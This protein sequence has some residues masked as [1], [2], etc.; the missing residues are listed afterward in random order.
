MGKFDSFR[1]SKPSGQ[2]PVARSQEGL[3]TKSE[4]DRRARYV[5]L[6]KDAAAK[7][8]IA[9]ALGQNNSFAIA[10]DAT[11]SMACLID[12]A[13][14]SITTILN[15]I[16]EESKVRV[17][18]QI[19][20]YRD[21]DVPHAICERS[22]RTRDSQELVRW[23]EQVRVHGGGANEGE[24]IEAVFEA[25]NGDKRPNAV[26]LAGDEPSN[27]RSDLDAR[28]LRGTKTAHDWASKFGDTNVPI[29]TFV[30]G[31]DPRTVKDFACISRMSGGQTGRLDGSAAM[32]DMAVM[33]MLASL[34]GSTSVRG[35]MERYALSDNAK[36][37]GAL[38]LSGPGATSKK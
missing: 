25:I 18:I 4:S 35:Y 11:G 37:F 30:V 31:Q 23:L 2:V 9:G 14:K 29:H 19:F 38:L 26:L 16:Y 33:A 32:I 3:P 27:P 34:K 10:L 6:G 15:R 7:G 13:K 17:A 28:G 21:Y 20:A 24:A 5:T 1:G 22:S 36:E 8:E 12:D